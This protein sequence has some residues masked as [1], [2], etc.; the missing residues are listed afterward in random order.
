M[1][2]SP[3]FKLGSYAERY[4]WLNLTTLKT[5]STKGDLIEVSKIIKGMDDML[6]DKM[7]KTHNE[8]IEKRSIMKERI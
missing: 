8:D 1:A 5:G 2:W 7:F 6:L 4:K 3:Y